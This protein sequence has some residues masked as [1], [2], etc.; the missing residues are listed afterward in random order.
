MVDA[1]DGARD[2]D[3]IV[4]LL[5]E[6]DEAIGVL[7]GVRGGEV[8]I[9]ALSRLGG[10]AML[11]L[12]RTNQTIDWMKNRVLI[13]YE[14]NPDGPRM[15]WGVWVLSSPK[16]MRDMVDHY[17]VSLLSKMV[18]VDEDTIT[19][20]LSFPAGTLVTP[21]V[22]TL[23][24]STGEVRP[25]AL[26]PSTRTTTSPLMWEAGTSKLTIINDLLTAIDYSALWCDGTGQYRVEPYVNPKD[27][28]VRRSF[29][30]DDWSLIRP[31][32]TREQ[33]LSGIPNRVIIFSAGTDTDPAIVGLAENSDPASPFST[34]NRRVITRRVEVT[35]VSS[36]AEADALAERYL[37]SSMNPVASLGVTTAIVPLE[38]ND[39]VAFTDGNPAV[40][41]DATV[42]RMKVQLLYDSLCEHEWREI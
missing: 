20:S 41:R 16:L 1:W 11:Q 8:E 29:V 13:E 24:R 27:R 3:W 25:I 28:V 39:R 10:S 34:V 15:P 12:T 5:N 9:V 4:T 37:F 26:T 2:P 36:Q 30:A 42:L 32:W 40:T 38:R 19:D 17:D 35:D 7:D 18:I 6:R 33:D 23:I 21:E 14:L 31:G 22:E